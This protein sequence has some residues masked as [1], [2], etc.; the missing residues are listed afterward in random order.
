MSQLALHQ[1]RCIACGGRLV[2]CVVVLQTFKHFIELLV[3]VRTLCK[4]AY[5][6][7][8]FYCVMKLFILF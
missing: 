4:L 2:V 3:S 8:I 7:S 1:W 5:N 6:V